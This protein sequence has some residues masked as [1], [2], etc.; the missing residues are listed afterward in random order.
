MCLLAIGMS[1]L[2]KCLFRF[3]AHFLVGLFGFLMLSCVS[4]F[5]IL[6][7][8]SLLDISFENIFSY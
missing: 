1:S 8:N 3:S 4:S 6:A 2:E 5:Y 7:I